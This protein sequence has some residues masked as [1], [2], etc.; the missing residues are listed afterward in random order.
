M[1]HYLDITITTPP[2][3]TG[4]VCAS[5]DPALFMPEKGASPL[6]AKAICATC[7]VTR[8][9]LSYA[10]TEGI[11]HGVW[12]GLTASERRTQKAAAA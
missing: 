9:C 12:G 6:A 11:L 10:V 2:W 3:L 7:P 1:T 4:A 8:A 5:T